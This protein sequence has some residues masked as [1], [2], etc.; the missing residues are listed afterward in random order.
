MPGSTFKYGSN[1][2]IVTRRPRAESRLPKLDAVSP[3][4]RDEAT[5]PVTNRCLVCFTELTGH[6]TISARASDKH[7]A[8][9]RLLARPLSC[10]QCE[11]FF[12][13]C[14]ASLRIG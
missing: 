10:R 6:Q 7:V 1:F 9:R 11:Q 12:S 4:P 3:L 2:C 8:R 14:C 13:V 5:P